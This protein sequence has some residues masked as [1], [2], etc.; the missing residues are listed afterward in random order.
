MSDPMWSC[1]LVR[2]LHAPTH[3]EIA[4]EAMLA[5]GLIRTSKLAPVIAPSIRLGA[6][7]P[8][9][10]DKIL[11]AL[12]NGEALSVATVAERIGCRADSVG[13]MLRLLESRGRVRVY[14]PKNAKKR[15]RLLKGAC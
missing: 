9:M 15:Y 11:A 6:Q 13:K 1:V 12:A 3:L 2:D 14:T 4:T 5:Y 8:V 10:T 7:P